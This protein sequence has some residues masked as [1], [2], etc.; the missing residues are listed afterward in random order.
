MKYT[1]RSAYFET[2]E[3]R[4]TKHFDKT[5]LFEVKGLKLSI[6]IDLFLNIREGLFFEI[7]LFSKN[8]AY[9]D[10]LT[11]KK[12]FLLYFLLLSYRL[13]GHRPLFTPNDPTVR[14][15][16]VLFGFGL[17]N[18]IGKLMTVLNS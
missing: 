4:G 5:F 14:A 18:I 15:L 13:E 9:F 7:K 16:L 12:I 17:K 11:D 3:V 2:M 8:F 1:C 6:S 10:L